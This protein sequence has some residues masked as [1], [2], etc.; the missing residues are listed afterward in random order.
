MVRAGSIAGAVMGAVV[1]AVVGVVIAILVC[2]YVRLRPNQIVEPLH[3]IENPCF[4]GEHACM[5]DCIIN[6][7]ELKKLLFFPTELHL[8]LNSPQPR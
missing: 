5:Q 7:R 4:E 3:L 8:H 2:W 1:G 6:L